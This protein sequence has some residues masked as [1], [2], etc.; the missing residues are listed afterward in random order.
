VVGKA[1]QLRALGYG[2]LADAILKRD[3]KKPFNLDD[4]EQVVLTQASSAVLSYGE[5]TS[6][7]IP[8]GHLPTAKS[9]VK[10]LATKTPPRNSKKKARKP[11][12][13]TPISAYRVEDNDSGHEPDHE[14]DEDRDDESVPLTSPGTIER[15][16][17]SWLIANNNPEQNSRGKKVS[18]LKRA[19]TDTVDESPSAKKVKGKSAAAAT[20]PEKPIVP[21]AEVSTISESSEMVLLTILG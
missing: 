7:Y 2:K 18:S 15:D 6:E 13:A 21:W 4:H 17:Q 20:P 12:K 5:V 19:H 1:L 16:Y 10:P 11:L 9:L 14:S 3:A 8:S